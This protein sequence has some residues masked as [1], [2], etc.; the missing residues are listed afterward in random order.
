MLVVQLTMKIQ[1]RKFLSWKTDCSK[2]EW[3][4]EKRFN[5]SYWISHNDFEDPH[6]IYE[7]TKQKSKRIEH[8]IMTLEL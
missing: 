7:I 1:M 6:F 4:G 3:M 8:K 2:Q 5:L